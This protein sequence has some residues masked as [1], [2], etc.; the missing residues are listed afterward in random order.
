MPI[1]LEESSMKSIKTKWLGLSVLTL[2]VALV[3]SLSCGGGVVTPDLDL[4]SVLDGSDNCPDVANLDQS[5]LDGD[6]SGNACDTDADGDGVLAT[7]GDCDDLN[8]S[9]KP[10]VEDNPDTNLQDLNCDGT[11]GDLTKAIWVA[12]DGNDATGDG[13]IGNPFRTIKKGVDQAILD[14]TKDVYVASGT[15]DQT[16]ILELKGIRIF[17]GFFGWIRRWFIS[18]WCYI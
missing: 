6:G 5:D 10:G 1:N 16:A 7:A 9:A 3:G 14:V 12:G 15:F 18:S 4:D 17:G 2:S 13:S 11:D 8:A